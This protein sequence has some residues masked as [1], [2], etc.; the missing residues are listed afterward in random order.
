MMCSASNRDGLIGLEANMPFVDSATI[1]GCERDI[2][3]VEFRGV[4]LPGGIS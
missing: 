1:C 3:K 4:L 2:G